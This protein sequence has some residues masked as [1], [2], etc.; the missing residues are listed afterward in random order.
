MVGFCWGRGGI[1]QAFIQKQ[2]LLYPPGE[3]TNGSFQEI[4]LEVVSGGWLLSPKSTID[5]PSTFAHPGRQLCMVLNKNY[6]VV[7]TK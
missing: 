2:W 4:Q 3:E 6:C 7:W 1:K 5:Q